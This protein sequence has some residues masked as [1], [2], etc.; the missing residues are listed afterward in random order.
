M[1]E[2]YLNGEK[3]GEVDKIALRESL[4]NMSKGNAHKTLIVS[5]SVHAECKI[6]DINRKNVLKLF[7][8]KIPRKL[9]KK[10]WGTRSSRRRKR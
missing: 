3:I 9:K 5:E 1:Y 8:R 4:E 2:M 10:Y 6:I 7:A